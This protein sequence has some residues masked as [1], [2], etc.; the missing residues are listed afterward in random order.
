MLSKPEG[1]VQRELFRTPLLD[2][3]DLSHPLCKLAT[4]IEWATFDEAFGELYSPDQG[5][6][7]KPTRL[8]V[9]LQYLKYTYNLSDEEVVARW[10]ENPYWQY[11][12]GREYF[13]HEVP[14]EPS[15]MTK[16]R[17][18]VK[19]QGMERLLTATIQAGLDTKVLKRR[20]LSK[21][22]VDT[23]VQEKAISFPTDAKL[24]HKLREKLVKLA[25]TCDIEL[26]QSYSRK[27][28]RALVMQGRYAHAR[29][30]KRARKEL[31]KLKTYLGRVKR[32]IERKLSGNG[33]LKETFSALL[34]KAERLLNQSRES[35][36]KLYSLHAP[37]VECIA[38]GKAHKKYEFGSKVSVVSPSGDNFVVG[39]QSFSGN[40][41][42]GHTLQQAVAQSER[43][44]GF[45]AEEIYVD[46][47]YRGHNYQGEAEVHIARK[48]IT[49]L[50]K[51]L[52]KW[53][54]RRSAI[55]PLIGHMKNNGRLDRNHLLGVEGDK[56]NAILCGCGFNLRK[57]LIAFLFWLFILGQFF[58][59]RRQF[60]LAEI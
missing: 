4:V 42:D 1:N 2:I 29:Q 36:N 52:I 45:K 17:N 3:I 37:E 56:I 5:R 26:R 27:S 28:R 38:K 20:S 9:G 50:K 49:G 47:G 43:L 41:Y 60:R 16:W 14:I 54:K 31:R 55:E 35:K 24:Y 6:P 12:C 58:S 33:Q 11:F 39:I 48:K 53:L 21:V 59:L 25:K 22:T 51:S 8:M 7:A 57:L 40:P 30:M 18:R 13:E 34:Q 44:A 46:Q 23:T 19:S 10:V 32:D 15:S